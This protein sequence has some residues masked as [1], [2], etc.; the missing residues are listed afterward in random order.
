[1]LQHLRLLAIAAALGDSS[2]G[3][4]TVATLS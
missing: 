1:M 4:P 2:G 3:T